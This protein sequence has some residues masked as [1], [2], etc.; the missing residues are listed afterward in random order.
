MPNPT[1]FNRGN[2]ETSYRSLRG[3]QTARSAHGGAGIRYRKKRMPRCNGADT[4]FDV[5][6]RESGPTS[7]WWY[8]ARKLVEPL[9]WGDCKWTLHH[10]ACAPPA[11]SQDM[12][13]G[14]G[15]VSRRSLGEH[16]E[17][18][19]QRLTLAFVLLEPSDR[20]L[21]RSVPRGLGAG[22][23]AWLPSSW[24]GENI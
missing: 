19:G 21:S 14:C 12:Y 18:L 4:G 24:Y 6:R 11:L 13:N 3:Q 10:W 8:V 5:T 17:L 16:S 20:K 2:V 23:R 15:C 22:N 7:D 9:V 1:H